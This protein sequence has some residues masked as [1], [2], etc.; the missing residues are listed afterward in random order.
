MACVYTYEYPLRKEWRTVKYLNLPFE[1]FNRLNNDHYLMIDRHNKMILSLGEYKNH[2]AINITLSD[3]LKDI[4]INSMIEYTR[5][6]LF[7][8]YR[9]YKNE[10]VFLKEPSNRSIDYIKKIGLGDE[11]NFRSMRYSYEIRNNPSMTEFEK[12]EIAQ[13]MRTS[14][15]ELDKTYKKIDD[16]IIKPPSSKLIP[17]LFLEVPDEKI[18]E[19]PTVT[20]QYE[21]SQE[22]RRMSQQK[23]Y[24]KNRLLLNARKYVHKLN[25]PEDYKSRIKNKPSDKKI[26]QY[27]LKLK[28]DGT[29]I[30][31]L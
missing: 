30:T 20:N 14:A 18:S 23:Y 26:E 9:I 1:R 13:L 28:S 10:I 3:E 29:W 4:I 31:E 11:S 21:K 19:I 2:P 17:K 24:D 5:T 12:D 22:T 7:E 25:A 27:K 15:S 16:N 8:K 6:F